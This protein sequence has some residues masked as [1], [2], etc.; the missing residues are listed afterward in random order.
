MYTLHRIPELVSQTTE[1]YK[2]MIKN[3]VFCIDVKPGNMLVTKS[4]RLYLIDF[5]DQFCASKESSIFTGEHIY[6]YAQQLAKL[7]RPENKHSEEIVNKGFLGLNLL[8]TG[9]CMLIDNIKN[10]EKFY[11]YARRLVAN[12]IAFTKEDLGSIVLCSYIP[13]SEII[14]R[15]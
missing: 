6:L 7:W 15:I 5:D 2:K 4:Y 14:I 9:V 8:Q 10:E 1:L 13:V 3:K 11:E 12:N